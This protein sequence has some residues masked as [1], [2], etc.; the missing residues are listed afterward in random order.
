M[1][2]FR[3]FGLLALGVLALGLAATAPAAAQRK[4]AVPT[5]EAAPD[6]E[7]Y[8]PVPGVFQRGIPTPP[9]GPGLPPPPGAAGPQEGAVP[10][11]GGQAKG[12]QQPQYGV[13]RPLDPEGG[14]GAERPLPED[15]DPYAKDPHPEQGPVRPKVAAKG[16]APAKGG[17]APKPIEAQ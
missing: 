1:V 4:H 15:P 17:P 5:K 14:Y 7:L 10:A 13:E 2:I 12:L 6:P 9:S 16:G 8:P 11:P 3:R